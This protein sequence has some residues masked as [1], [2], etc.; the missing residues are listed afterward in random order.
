MDVTD[1]Q[2][3]TKIKHYKDGCFKISEP[4]YV[5]KET[6]LIKLPSAFTREELERFEKMDCFRRFLESR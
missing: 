5:H 3:E 6:G 2:Q 1:W 4:F